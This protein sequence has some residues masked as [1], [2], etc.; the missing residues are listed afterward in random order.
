LL[1]LLLEVDK[2]LFSSFE[3]GS[4]LLL[5]LINDILVLFGFLDVVLEGEK[6]QD[7]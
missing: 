1:C 2:L 4:L 5:R 6:L 7:L 3:I